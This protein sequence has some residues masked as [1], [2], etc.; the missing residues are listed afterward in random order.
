M[1]KIIV[2]FLFLFGLMCVSHVD[3]QTY[4]YK[5]FQFAYKVKTDSGIWSNWSDWESSDMLLTINMDTDVIT[6]Y[7]SHKQVYKVLDDEGSY[8]DESGGKQ[9]KFYVVDQD[10]D[11]GY[12]RLRIEKNGNSQVYVDFGDIMWVYNVKRI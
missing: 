10:G 1:K 4:Y 3:A 9:Q 8:T 12:V 6:V 2:T 5:T 11:F 7:S